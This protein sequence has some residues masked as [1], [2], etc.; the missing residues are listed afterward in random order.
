M[1]NKRRKRLNL[2]QIDRKQAARL[3]RGSGVGR[4][5]RAALHN[6][7]YAF[8]YTKPI[9]RRARRNRRPAVHAAL[10]ALPDVRSGRRAGAGRGERHPARHAG[11]LTL[12]AD[13]ERR[14]FGRVRRELRRALRAAHRRPRRGV[15]RLR[16]GVP[17]GPRDRRRAGGHAVLRPTRF[18]RCSARATPTGCS[19]PHERGGRAA[20][21]F[22][23]AAAIFFVWRAIASRRGSGGRYSV[24]SIQT[25]SETPARTCP[26]TRSRPARRRAATLSSVS[27]RRRIARR[28]RYSFI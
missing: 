27:R 12:R 14:A 28:M 22:A 19:P 21:G 3:R 20:A 11:R 6:H 2:S 25:A 17:R 23:P 7:R 16:H 8:A 9:C 5:G 13:A 10:Y 26:A 15:R 4:A 18:A 1:G 24:G